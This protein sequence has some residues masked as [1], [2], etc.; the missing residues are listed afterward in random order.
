ML[1][2]TSWGSESSSVVGQIPGPSITFAGIGGPSTPTGNAPLEATS[3]LNTGP[4]GLESPKKAVTCCPGRDL[5]SLKELT[6]TLVKRVV[7]GTE[8]IAQSTI[9]GRNETL[10]QNCCIYIRSVVHGRVMGKMS[11]QEFELVWTKCLE[12]LSKY[13]QILLS[14]RKKKNLDFSTE[15]SQKNTSKSI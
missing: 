2:N 12:S 1:G 8:I 10:Q 3:G 15:A 9:S 7:F 13:R 14:K 5:S 6:V 11:D 4:F